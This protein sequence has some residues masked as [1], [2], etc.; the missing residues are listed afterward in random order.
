MPIASTRKPVR[1]ADLDQ[2]RSHTPD[3]Y[4][5]RMK[6]GH[7]RL[8]QLQH[9]L[10]G[11]KR[12]VI[13]VVEGP[14]AAGKGGAIKRLVERLDP[15]HIRV[16][17]TIKPT[18]EEYARHYLWRFWNKLPSRGELAIFDRS[19]YGRVLV[20]R[21]EG[22]C[23]KDEWK[24]AYRELNEFERVLQDDGTILVKMWLHITKEEQMKRFK[25]RQADPMKRW[26]MNEEDWRNRNRWNDYVKAAEE[27]FVRTSPRSA[28]WHV[29]P[30]NYKWFARVRVLETVCERL[31]AA[32]GKI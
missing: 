4:R 1:L 24:R 12:S 19:W 2:T 9:A 6:E 8:L 26:K 10:K 27:M 7:L 32:L 11:S 18:T 31:T 17:S 13:I 21:V 30:A 28:P 23:T 16:Y 22:F 20:E 29:I 3:H 15:R 5:E 14:D 25:K